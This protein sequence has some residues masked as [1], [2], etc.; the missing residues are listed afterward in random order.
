MKPDLL[1][2]LARISRHYRRNWS[3]V[4][5]VAIVVQCLFALLP[6]AVVLLL[7]ALAAHASVAARLAAR[8]FVWSGIE[9]SPL[10]LTVLVEF[11]G[12]V[13]AAGRLCWPEPSARHHALL[14]CAVLRCSRCRDRQSDAK[15]RSA[16]LRLD[17]DFAVVVADEAPHDI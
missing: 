11:S 17:C 12:N 9:V 1:G 7:A 13:L 10:L 2:C 6:V 5:V 4:S 16:R 14:L 8:W 15:L 3:F